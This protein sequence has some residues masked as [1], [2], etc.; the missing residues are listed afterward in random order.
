[1]DN[2]YELERQRTENRERQSRRR[3]HRSQKERDIE[4]ERRILICY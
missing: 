2:L 3:Q 1:M 4:N